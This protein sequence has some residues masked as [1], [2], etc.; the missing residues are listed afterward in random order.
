MIKGRLF[1]IGVALIA[2]VLTHVPAPVDAGGPRF[3]V[4]SVLAHGG[5][6]VAV[7][8]VTRPPYGVATL[9]GKRLKIECF[10]TDRAIYT[11][12][13][14]LFPVVYASYYA[15]QAVLPN[16]QRRWI[17][18]AEFAPFASLIVHGQARGGPCGTD[19]LAS[20]NFAV[21]YLL[22]T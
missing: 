8:A 18:G 3:A 7:E 5:N 22:I 1:V 6:V 16:G 4:H 9:N 14:P 11:T 12:Y 2:G 13:N 15:M 17:I 10:K 19:A 20:A 21:G